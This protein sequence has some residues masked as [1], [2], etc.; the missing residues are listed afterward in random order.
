[1]GEASTVG[2]RWRSIR[3]A[4]LLAATMTAIL[5]GPSALPARAGSDRLS[6]Q[7]FLEQPRSGD[8][9]PVSATVLSGSVTNARGVTSAGHGRTILT[10]PSGGSP[11]TVLLD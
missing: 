5:T 8:V 9:R 7:S 10:V 2:H 4:A 3:R 6:W 1:M 11:A